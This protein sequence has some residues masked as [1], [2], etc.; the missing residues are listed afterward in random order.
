VQ[1]RIQAENRRASGI[2][3]QGWS[4]PSRNG[5]CA[6]RSC[7]RTWRG[8]QGQGQARPGVAAG[9]RWSAGGRICG[10]YT[11]QTLLHSVRPGSVAMKLLSAVFAAGQAPSPSLGRKGDGWWAS[12]RDCSCC[13]FS[14]I[15]A[16]KLGAVFG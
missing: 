7:R 1:V 8:S 16:T 3:V 5:P 9:G 15:A 14:L 13:G 2:R 10:S 12:P 6:R 4:R 11:T